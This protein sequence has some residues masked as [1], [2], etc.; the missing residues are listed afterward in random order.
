MVV[1]EMVVV[2][3][4]EVVVE[5]VVVLEEEIVV[6]VVLEVDEPVVVVVK[7]TTLLLLLVL[8]LHRILLHDV[9]HLKIVSQLSLPVPPPPH[10]QL[11]ELHDLS[12]EPA[13]QPKH[14][15]EFSLAVQQKQ[16]Q[17]ILPLMRRRRRK[18][19]LMRTLMMMMMGPLFRLQRGLAGVI[20]PRGIRMQVEQEPE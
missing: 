5:V 1:L 13:V 8:V 2:V 3:L 15:P 17:N 18:R 19:T 11:P 9:I 16:D 7:E 14:Q 6:V 10:S 12:R 4:E 20:I